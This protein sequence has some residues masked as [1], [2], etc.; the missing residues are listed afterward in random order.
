MLDRHPYNAAYGDMSPEEYEALKASVVRHGFYDDEVTLFDNLILDGWHRY[1]VSLELDY[2]MLIGEF[3]GSDEDAR[4]FVKTLNLRR[5]HLS[6]RKRAELGGRVV[7]DKST[8]ELRRLRHL[9]W[10]FGMDFLHDEVSVHYGVGRK[11]EEPGDVKEAFMV[12]RDAEFDSEFCVDVA[13]NFFSEVIAPSLLFADIRAD[14][15]V[16]KVVR[17][18]MD[19]SNQS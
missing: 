6:P 1:K 7:R 2:E 17:E 5:R 12:A 18:A 10:M 9:V 8:D 14:V 15:H 11:W 16:R 19:S 4:E 13:N 3:T